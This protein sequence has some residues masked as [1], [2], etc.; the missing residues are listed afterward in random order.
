MVNLCH[1]KSLL[2][3]RVIDVERTH[4]F[5]LAVYKHKDLSWMTLLLEQV[6]FLHVL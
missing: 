6:D 4:L 3:V 2:G 5:Y 1:L